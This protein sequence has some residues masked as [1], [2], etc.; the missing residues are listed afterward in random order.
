MLDVRGLSGLRNDEFVLFMDVVVSLNEI[1]DL[2]Y[3]GYFKELDFV[4]AY[5]L[6]FDGLFL[7]LLFL[8]TC[9]YACMS[10]P[11]VWYR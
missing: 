10:C 7:L 8:L 2:S 6:Y 4:Y 5:Y 3:Y 1:G 11:L 9:L